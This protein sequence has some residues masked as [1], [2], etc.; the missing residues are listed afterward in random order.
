[1]NNFVKPLEW[2][3]ISSKYSLW[4]A[5][6]PG[7]PLYRYKA[8]RFI[9]E[10]IRCSFELNVYDVTNALWEEKGFSTIEEAKAACEK[11]Y[12]E[13]VLSLLLPKAVQ[14]LLKHDS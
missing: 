3:E 1:M 9:D 13:F 12:E 14:L 10:T 7:I 4:T 2:E 5:K 11:H 8:L 6:F